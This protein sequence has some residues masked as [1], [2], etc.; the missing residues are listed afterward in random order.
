MI[1]ENKETESK[2]IH[3]TFQFPD[4]ITK[5]FSVKLD[6]NTLSLIHTAKETYPDWTKLEYCQ[7]PNCPLSTEDH[8]RCPIALNLS[9]LIDSFSDSISYENVSVS[10]VTD[11]R[12]YHLDT[13]LQRV[14]SSLIGIY[15]V[16]SD[17]PIMDKLRPM[18]DSHLPFAT[19]EETTYRMITMYLMAQYFRNKHG[20]DP[21]WELNHFVDLMREISSVDIAFSKRLRSIQIKDAS[22]NAITILHT[23][24]QSASFSIEEQDLSRMESIFMKH[25]GD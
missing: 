10:I 1:D 17:C 19:S 6:F 25:Y 11:A 8:L 16:T 15:M 21:D 2:E 24:G 23:Y 7:C 14:L 5:E 12:A 18:V 13:T 3:Y 4:G 22:L 9:D 20:K